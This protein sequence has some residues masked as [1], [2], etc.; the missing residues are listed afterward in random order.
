LQ[1]QYDQ[2]NQAADESYNAGH[3]S[4]LDAL[5]KQNLFYSSAGRNDLAD[6]LKRYTDAQSES[7]RN[8]Q[9][10]L[11]SGSNGLR[12]LLGQIDNG[13]LTAKQKAQADQQAASQA[14]YINSLLAALNGGT[15]DSS[16]GTYVPGSETQ[17]PG[18]IYP[19]QT[20]V[21]YLR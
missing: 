14:A 15:T 19:D 2:G 21:P 18:Y 20:F 12:S 5:N 6:A 8:Y 1:H 4:L 10:T 7:A 16:T 3:A 17:V 13:V 11:S 9:G